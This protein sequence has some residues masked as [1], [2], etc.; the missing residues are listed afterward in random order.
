MFGIKLVNISYFCLY[1]GYQFVQAKIKKTKIIKDIQRLF[2]YVVRPSFDLTVQF[3]L[4]FVPKRWIADQK[5]VKNNPTGPQIYSFVVRFLLQDLWRQVPRRPGET[6]PPQFVVVD[7]DGQSKVGKLTY[8]RLFFAG[9]KKIFGFEVS[10]YDIVLVAVLDTL[11][12]LLYAV[13]SVRLAVIFPSHN[14][15]EKFSASD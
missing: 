12:H 7:F 15:L 9:K 3:L 13:G 8:S 4:I 10:V 14:L 6:E 1:H 2:T 11:Q 5:N